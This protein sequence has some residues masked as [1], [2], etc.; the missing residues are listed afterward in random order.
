MELAPDRLRRVASRSVTILIANYTPDRLEIE[1]ES[2]QLCRGTWS[3]DLPELGVIKP[4]GSVLWRCRSAHIGQ[5]IEGFVTY[6]FAGQP[7]HDRVKFTWKNRYFGPNKY[8]GETSREGYKIVVEGG[9][10]SEAF[11]AFVI[12]K[13]G[14]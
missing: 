9:Q 8:G 5:G 7:P 14:D 11:V 4:G 13:Q 1:S 10:G 2:M 3:E 12:S 6:R